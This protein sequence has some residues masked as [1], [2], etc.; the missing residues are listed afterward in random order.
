MSLN[1][2]HLGA[3][4]T[5]LSHHSPSRVVLSILRWTKNLSSSLLLAKVDIMKIATTFASLAA[6][7]A[8]VREYYHVPD[9]FVEN[10]TAS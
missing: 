5:P 7:A 6:V 1:T 10:S 2:R 4:V 9:D 3:V 8:A